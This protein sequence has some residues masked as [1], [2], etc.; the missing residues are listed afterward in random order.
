MGSAKLLL[1]VALEALLDE[2]ICAGTSTF[3]ALNAHQRLTACCDWKR[4]F[5]TERWIV[6]M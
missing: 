3:K 5:E 2:R 1:G 4:I 6:A